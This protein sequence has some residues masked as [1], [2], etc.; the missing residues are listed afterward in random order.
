[1]KNKNIFIQLPLLVM[2]LFLVFALGCKREEVPVV[3]TTEVTNI[4]ISTATSGGF[5]EDDGGVGIIDCGVCWSTNDNPTINDSKTIDT[6]GTFGFESSIK[7]LEPNKTYYVRA[8][9]TN[10]VGTGYG[11][12]ISFT[13]HGFGTF[14]DPR[15][16]SVYKTIQIGDQIWMAENLK[17]LPYVIGP[18]TGSDAY[19]Y[20][21]VYGYDGTNAVEAKETATYKTYGVLYNWTAVMS[22]AMNSNNNPSGV[23]GVCPEG[24]HVP[25]E[26]EW[27]ELTDFLGGEIVAGGKLKETGTEHWKTPNEGATNEVG[28]TAL[29]N[30][31]RAHFGAYFFSLGEN[32]FWW[33]TTKGID[34]DK[35]RSIYMFYQYN[36]M[37]TQVSFKRLGGA[38]RCVKN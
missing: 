6:I 38:V 15:D 3:S 30:G 33:T 11:N 4:T 18:E 2:G 17:Y 19:P 34:N 1:M 16:G 7:G 25:S 10:S 24:W 14:T 36:N 12:V 5:I 32:G 28:F 37:N 13:T 29:P 23:R 35:A 22:G 26:A 27:K 8:Y 31:A 21:Y 9:A 20:Y